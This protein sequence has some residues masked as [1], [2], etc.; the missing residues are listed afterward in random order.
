MPC[1]AAVDN[2][3]AIEASRGIN[4]PYIESH[5]E[6]IADRTCAYLCSQSSRC[7]AFSL[8]DGPYCRLFVSD[9]CSKSVRDCICTRRGRLFVMKRPGLELGSLCP[10]GYRDY[11]CG[12]KYRLYPDVGNWTMAQRK[13]QAE[14]RLVIMADVTDTAEMTYV[15]Q[16]YPRKSHYFWLGGQQTASSTEPADG[17][18]WV[19]CGSSVDS[20][21]WAREEPNNAPEGEEVVGRQSYDGITDLWWGN[22]AITH[23]LRECVSP[24]V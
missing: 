21:F 2:Y 8:A 12:V 22:F 13:C 4:S 7:Q 23:V 1:C 19:A 3:E 24:F 18:H 9:G 14:L 15:N 5:P 11:R 17:W 20:S 10:S 16:L 6:V